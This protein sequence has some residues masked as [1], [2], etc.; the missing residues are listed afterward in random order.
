MKQRLLSGSDKHM[1]EAFI[2]LVAVFFSSGFFTYGAD[3]N[4]HTYS[5]KQFP[6]LLK[7]CNEAAKDLG[8]KF[9]KATGQVVFNAICEKESKDGYD[10][11]ITYVSASPLPLV[12]TVDEPG[13]LGAHGLFSNLDTCLKDLPREVDAFTKA[14]GLVPFVSYCLKESSLNLTPYVARVDG[15]GDAEL[16]PNRFEATIFANQIDKAK[17]VLTKIQESAK[18]SG[19]PVHQATFAQDGNLKLVVRYYASPKDKAIYSTYFKINEVSRYSSLGATS[20]M[21]VCRRELG[22]LSKGFSSSF[23]SKGVFFCAW[24]KLLFEARLYIVRIRRT[25]G[26][27][28]EITP[29]RYANYDECERE[30]SSVQSFYEKKLGITPFFIAC[31][32]KSGLGTGKP[33]AFAMRVLTKTTFEEEFPSW[34]DLGIRNRR[35]KYE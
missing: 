27:K 1:K 26:I 18:T 5:L 28:S 14:T 11:V 33:D 20:P 2:L 7:S 9:T 15:W 8:E 24:D 34:P 3:T 16:Y 31:T 19:V 35:E 4:W 12:S 6:K 10:I 21:E 29:L 25:E 32:W 13:G 30:K 23:S 17:E 22:E